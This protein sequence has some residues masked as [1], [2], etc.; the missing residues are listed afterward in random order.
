M[1]ARTAEARIGI[2]LGILALVLWI[3]F[4]PFSILG[5]A[6]LA[7]RYALVATSLILLTG[8]VGQI[9]LAQASFVG[10]AAYVTGL[11]TRSWQVPFPLTLPLA[12]GV[13]AGVAA[14]LGVV[15]LRVRGL[16][17][18]VATLIFAWMT[19]AFL[20][21]Q[22]WFAGEGGS[23]TARINPLGDRGTWPYLDFTNRK[24]FYYISLAVLLTAMLAAANLRA[25]KTGRAW[26]ALR[27]S[28]FAAASLGVDITRYK[29]IAFATSGF[30]AGAAGSLFMTH[31]Q[32]ATATSFALP[33]SLFFLAV[34][35]VGGLTRL[36]GAV[37]GAVVFASL[38]E[39]FFRFEQLAGLLD[40]VSAILLGAVLLFFPAGLSGI[41]E[42]AA[43]P[44]MRLARR[45]AGT[46][47]GRA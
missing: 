30:M 20:F 42:R 8:W 23:L 1:K 46:R 27:G 16:Y 43:P 9:S 34:A 11:L 24:V 47:A 38:E 18:A 14:L 40:V 4:A 35:V 36:S 45:A 5:T 33:V 31:Q 32:V 13:A 6:N 39:V 17:L 26:F 29:L 44:A 37:L 2:A 7:L 41:A 10:V 3:H 28:E 22:A 25:S 15:A 19:Q 12:A 21:N